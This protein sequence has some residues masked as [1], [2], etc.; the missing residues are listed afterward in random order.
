MIA[1]GRL[2]LALQY[3]DHSLP[4]ALVLW[5]EGRFPELEGSWPSAPTRRSPRCRP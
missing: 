1:P 3:I 5:S 2:A 4:Q